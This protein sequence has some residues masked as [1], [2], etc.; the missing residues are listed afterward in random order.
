MATIYN[1]E[2]KTVSPFCAFDED[3]MKKMLK[4]FFKEYQDS[5]TGLRFE[6]TEIK[7]ER[8]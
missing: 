7:V 5:E 8:K 3:Y 1:I 2:I 6:N 4:K